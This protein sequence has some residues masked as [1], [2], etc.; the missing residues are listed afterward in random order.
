VHCSRCGAPNEPGDRFC[1]ACG[2]TLKEGSSPPQRSSLRERAG[3]LIGTT[4]KARLITVATAV[5]IA[6]AI[7]AFIA[8]KPSDDSIPRDSYTIAAD[9]LCLAAKSEIVAVERHFSGQAGRGDTSAFA[10]ELLP[11][12]ARWRSRLR[13]MAVPTD[14]LEQARQLEAAL[15]KA[16]VQI[17][18][19]AR[20]AARG[21]DEKTLA[22]AK[23]ADVASAGVEEAAASLG[24]D[25]CAGATIGLAQ[26]QG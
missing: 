20:V 18:V 6:V 25:R 8:L 14:R 17:A 5:S 1:S 24:L 23:Q 13:E 2:A 15:L 16:E 9:R 12:V 11:V 10:R 7:V 26:S 3:L 4:R 21:D 19:L 22:S